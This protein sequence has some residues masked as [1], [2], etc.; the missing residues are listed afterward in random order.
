MNAERGRDARAIGGGEGRN[1]E[2]GTDI[3]M[4]TEKT[5]R[6]KWETSK[7]EAYQCAC[8]GKH[9]RAVINDES[10]NFRHFVGVVSVR[11]VDTNREV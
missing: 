9:T 2:R 3:L 1:D 6:E 11:G 5:V 8:Q 10:L 4:R 7:T